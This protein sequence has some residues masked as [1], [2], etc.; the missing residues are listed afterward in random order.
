M[1]PVRPATDVR[2][3]LAFIAKENGCN[4]VGFASRFGY[5][6]DEARKILNGL[7]RDGLVTSERAPLGGSHSPVWGSVNNWHLTTDGRKRLL[8]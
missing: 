2:V 7:K 6:T 3:Y 1:M 5:Y 8:T 4:T